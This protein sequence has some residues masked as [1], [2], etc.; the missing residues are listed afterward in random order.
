MADSKSYI[1]L[2]WVSEEITETLKQASESLS[3]FI[4]NPNDVTKLRF[5]MTYTF[6]A[7]GSLK[8]I[9]LHSPAQLSA[10]LEVLLGRALEDQ[11]Q[12]LAFAEIV[13]NGLQVLMDYLTETAK[14]HVENPNNLLPVLNDIRAALNA[15]EASPGDFFDPNLNIHKANEQQEADITEIEFDD[16]MR[17]MR[18]SFQSGLIGI[19][20]NSELN[21]NFSLINKV[22]ANLKTVSLKTASASFWEIAAALTESLLQKNIAADIDEKKALKQIDNQLKRLHANGR[23]QFNKTVDET[24]I[25][26]L[27]YCVAN[28]SQ[29]TETVIALRESYQLTEGTSGQQQSVQERVFVFIADNLHAAITEDGGSTCTLRTSELLLGYEVDFAE[30]KSSL[31]SPEIDI[32]AFY[33]RLNLKLTDNRERL[34]ALKEQIVEYVA[35]PWQKSSIVSFSELAHQVVDDLNYTFFAEILP[36]LTSAAEYVDTRCLGDENLEPD[37]TQI[38]ALADIISSVEYYLDC[39]TS[40]DHKQLEHIIKLGQANIKALNLHSSDEETVHADAKHLND[41]SALDIDEEILEIFVEEAEDV[42][43]DIQVALPTIRENKIDENALE[44]LTRAFHTLRGSGRMVGADAMADFAWSLENM[45]DKVIAGPVTLTHGGLAAIEAAAELLPYIIQCFSEKKNIQQSLLD[46]VIQLAESGFENKAQK[47][48]NNN[49]NTADTADAE[50]LPQTVL[51]QSLNAGIDKVNTAQIITDQALELDIDEE[52]FEIFIEEGQEVLATIE[53]YLPKL[54][55]NVSDHA[56]LVEV[57]RAFHTLKGSGRMVGALDIGEFAWSIERMLNK[58]ME[59]GS[60][61]TDNALYIM[62]R[63]T[64]LIPALLD[65]FEKKKVAGGAIIDEVIARADAD[66]SGIDFIEPAVAQTSTSQTSVDIENSE[67]FSL[68]DI[69]AMDDADD[70]IEAM[71]LA[72]E[73]V[74]KDSEELDELAEIFIAEAQTHIDVLSA[75]LDNIDPGFSDVEVSHELQRAFHTLKGSAQMA[76]MHD[77]ALISSPLE[78]LIKDLANFQIKADAGVLAL[79]MRAHELLSESLHVIGHADVIPA[80]RIA[81][82]VDDVNALHKEKISQSASTDNLEHEDKQFEILTHALEA[83]TIAADLN[84]SWQADPANISPSEKSLLPQTLAKLADTAEHANYP[85]ISS[86]AAALGDFYVRVFDLA[87]DDD[88]TAESFILANEAQDSLDDMMDLVAANQKVDSALELMV[89]LNDFQN[90]EGD[91]A[92]TQVPQTQASANERVDEGEVREKEPFIVNVDIASFA[93]QLLG[94]D[95][96]MLE[97]FLEEANELH[98]ELEQVFFSWLAEPSHGAYPDQMKRILHTLKGGARL[99]E[100]TELGDIVHDY[101]SNIESHELKQ[102]FNDDFFYELKAYQVAVDKLMSAAESDPQMLLAGCDSEAALDDEHHVDP[103][104]ASTQQDDA[105]SAADLV[106][107]ASILF[108]QLRLEV[109]SA[110]EETLEIFMEEAIEL[111]EELE[112]AAN[113][114]SDD[115]SKIESAAALKRVLHTLKGGAR[116]SELKTLGDLTHNYESMIEKHE[117][118]GDFSASFFNQMSDYQEQIMAAVDVISSSTSSPVVDPQMTMTQV[119]AEN[120]EAPDISAPIDLSNIETTLNINLE[121]ID[122]ELLSLFVE[123]STEN[124]ESI[125]IATASLI[126]GG[127]PKEALDE[128]KRVLH[129]LKGG[130]RLAGV[131]DIGDVS[132][133]FE[134]YIINAERENTIHEDGFI[135]EIQTYQDGLN[136]QI[137]EVQRLA[138]ITNKA[139]AQELTQS[140]VVP[141]RPGLE[142]ESINQAA[143]DATRSFIEGLNKDKARGNKEAIKLMPDQLQSMINLAGESLISRSRVEEVMSEMGFSLDEMDAT[144]D[145]LHGQLRRMEIETEAQISSRF[146]QLEVAGQ[147]N[148]DPLEMDRYSAMQQLSKLLIESASDLEDISD[149]INNKMRDM[150][151][152]LLQMGRI[153]NGLQEGLMRAQM[154]P[155]SKMVPRLHRIIRQVANELG[156]KIDFSVEN[157]EGELDRTILEKMIAPLEHMLRNAVDHGIEMPDQRLKAGKPELGNIILSLS[158]EGGEVVLTLKDNGAGVNIHAVRKK[159]VEQGLMQEDSTLS[160]NEIAQF[161]MHAGFS[162]A[163]KVTQISGRG[164]G[165]DVVHSEIKQMGGVVEVESVHGQGTTFIV[166]LPFTVSVNRA[167]MVTMAEDTYAI[168]LNTIEGIV[169]VSPYELEAYYQPDAPPFEYAGQNYNLKYMGGLLQRGKSVNLEGLTTPLPVILIRSSDYSVA[170]QV[171]HLLGSQEVVVKSLGP[172]FSMVEGVTGATVM[173][174]GDVVVILDMLA[175]IREDSQRSMDDYA[176]IHNIEEQDY[177]EERPL[178]VMVTDDSVT[179]RKVTSRFLERQGFEVVLA[180]DGQDAVTQLAEMAQLPDV[181]LLDIEM[182]RMDGFEV[183]NRVKHNAKMQDINIVMITSRTGEKHRERALSLGASRYLGKPFQEKELLQV[184]TELTGAEVLEA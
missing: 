25:K 100:L 127:N 117:L 161:I 112:Q 7:S 33:K 93:H 119:P 171:D 163:E 158:R 103:I 170:V 54:S 164:V 23:S 67:L 17:R 58:L 99:T 5:C 167:L 20:R 60:D 114:W 155:F 138:D 153:N 47:I 169:R 86:L 36:L 162:T 32:A 90:L 46:K 37:V 43:A 49:V 136:D 35:G 182:P 147:E 125:E 77:M 64:A 83:L 78:E 118:K 89:K 65:C 140:N 29:P 81:C 139:S 116:L 18:Q 51:T 41:E 115:H 109:A 34:D 96:E 92:E 28:D 168:P 39:F 154:V 172:Q 75:Y 12:R 134:T 149:T 76:D 124:I 52:I 31:A 122:S 160:D 101:E 180:K 121:D 57:R 108:D 6:Q 110:D 84:I 9:E 106:P 151:T 68:S 66:W 152:I 105:K 44:Q 13:Q 126:A 2:D 111:A 16:L 113:V 24:A 123:E 42:L 55:A 142:T 176:D 144:V 175:L 150:E 179:V 10:D 72:T 69:D 94:A 181:M 71:A 173:G 137:A 30:L 104:S 97:I 174:N 143:I 62:Q 148:F 73:N 40:Q 48:E 26:V 70:V 88:A 146:E 38:E 59:S 15:E 56:A 63:A 95:E 79:L 183:L 98:E 3:A 22:T 91:F 156:K 133:D 8:M 27:L 14:T 130:A 177:E 61:L 19:V 131:T 129:T 159:A 178:K 11:D 128:L 87:L 4:N 166:R 82:F 107:I 135:D 1:A 53:E 141:I 45:L 21:D 120:V 145:R 102:D 74:D 165:M 80:D 50:S 132:H 157:A 85:E 184:I